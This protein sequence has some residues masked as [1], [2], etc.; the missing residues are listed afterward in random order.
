MCPGLVSIRRSASFSGIRKPEGEWRAVARSARVLAAAA[1]ILV[2]G[3]PALAQYVFDPANADEQ[4]KPGTL[5]FGSAKDDGG[6]YLRDV[7]VVLEGQQTS[8]VLITSAAGR[9][10]GKFLID[11][12]PKDVKAACSK[13]GFSLLRVSKRVSTSGATPSVQIDCI[14]T[15]GTARAAAAAPPSDSRTKQ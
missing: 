1:A 2:A 15:R 6:R 10:R 7:T 13:A 9:F 5:Y 14:L 8:F 3:R 11:A 4:A 12:P